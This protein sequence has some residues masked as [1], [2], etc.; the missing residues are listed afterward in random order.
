MDKRWTMTDPIYTYD[1]DGDILYIAF[2]LGEKG[3]GVELNDFA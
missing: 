3:T 1:E 2:A